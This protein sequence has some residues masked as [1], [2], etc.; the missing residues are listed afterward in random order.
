MKTLSILCTTGVET[1]DIM[2]VLASLENMRVS[3]KTRS[4]RWRVGRGRIHTLQFNF[5][6]SDW[7]F[8]KYAECIEYVYCTPRT[9]PRLRELLLVSDRALERH[10]D[11]SIFS[12]LQSC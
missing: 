10:I 4:K 9:T 11:S 7:L 3:K 8:S 2:H 6:F 12:T 1:Y 5:L